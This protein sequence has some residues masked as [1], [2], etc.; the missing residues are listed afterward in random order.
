MVAP[1]YVAALVGSE[2]SRR[3]GPTGLAET[4]T[5]ACRHKEYARIFSVLWVFVCKAIAA[6][7]LRGCGKPRRLNATE[8]RLRA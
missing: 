3:A 5:N 6:E 7:N 4:M 1:P 8:K 2:P